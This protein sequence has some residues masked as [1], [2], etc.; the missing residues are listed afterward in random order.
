MFIGNFIA[1]WQES[2]FS[3]QLSDSVFY[4][5]FFLGQIAG[6]NYS[7]AFFRIVYRWWN[8]FYLVIHMKMGCTIIRAEKIAR[9]YVLIKLIVIWKEGKRCISNYWVIWRDGIFVF[10][11]CRLMVVDKMGQVF[12]LHLVTA[13]ISI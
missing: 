13:I 10:R 2:L 3:K 5:S 4:Y 12:L 8:I 9:W 6:I 11:C 7:S 1:Q